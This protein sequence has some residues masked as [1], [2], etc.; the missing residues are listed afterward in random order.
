MPV[1]VM[2]V[3]QGRKIATRKHPWSTMVSMASCPSLLGRPVMRSI[4]IWENG[5]ALITDGMWNIGGLMQC[6]RFLFCWHVAQPLMYSVIQVLV[7]GQKYS[8]LMH[9]MVS[10]H[11]GWPLIDPSCQTFISSHFRP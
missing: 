1:P 11:P 8:L 2:V 5:L 6:V 4:T 10:S 7:P 9:R 3:E